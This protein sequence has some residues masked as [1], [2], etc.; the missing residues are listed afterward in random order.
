MNHERQWWPTLVLPSDWVTSYCCFCV[1]SELE[2]RTDF[3]RDTVLEGKGR[4]PRLSV[5]C[6][7]LCD[8]HG[9]VTFQLLQR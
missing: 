8:M 1:D 5:A 9:T 2:A 7:P 4:G 6:P 3:L